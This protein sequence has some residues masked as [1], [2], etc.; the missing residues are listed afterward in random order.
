MRYVDVPTFVRMAEYVVRTF[1]TGKNPAR[2]F[3]CAN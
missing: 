2:S 3:K 1:H